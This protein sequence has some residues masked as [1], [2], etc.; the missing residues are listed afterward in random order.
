MSS[1]YSSQHTLIILRVTEFQRVLVT[2]SLRLR[3]QVITPDQSVKNRT[4]SG[5]MV[6]VA[7]MRKLTRMFYHMLKTKEHWRWEDCRLTKRKLSNLM[8]DRR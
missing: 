5:R 7:T 3:L 1:V 6:H 2:L 8:R 4:G